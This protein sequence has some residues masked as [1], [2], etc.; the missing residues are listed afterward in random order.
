MFQRQFNIKFNLM[1]KMGLKSSKKEERVNECC[2]RESIAKVGVQNS[3][4]GC[5]NCR[6]WF[7]L[8]CT[9]CISA[10]SEAT[11]FVFLRLGDGI[12]GTW[13][14]NRHCVWWMKESMEYLRILDEELEQNG[15]GPS[16]VVFFFRSYT[17]TSIFVRTIFELYKYT[18]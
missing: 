15:L 5:L 7:C 10:N 13:C 18:A 12:G 17:D 4:E 9:C 14:W 3:S 6:S 2:G 16:V 8:V 1:P 11:E